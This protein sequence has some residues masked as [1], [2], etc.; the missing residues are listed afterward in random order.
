MPAGGRRTT[1]GAADILADRDLV[2]RYRWLNVEKIVSTTPTCWRIG[3]LPR[4]TGDRMASGQGSLLREME[5]LD[6]H[7]R[8]IQDL[9]GR[10]GALD[11]AELTRRQLVPRRA[12]ARA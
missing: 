8:A 12:R 1:P 9:R 6:D 3:T 7:A 5:D 10:G 11:V 4:R 2:K